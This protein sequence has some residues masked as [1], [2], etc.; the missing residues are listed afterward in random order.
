MNKLIVKG[1]IASVVAAVL[2]TLMNLFIINMPIYHVV[3][4]FIICGGLFFS[5]FL[6][7]KIFIYD[8]DKAVLMGIIQLAD[9]IALIEVTCIAMTGIENKVNAGIAFVI[10]EFLFIGLLVTTFSARTLERKNKLS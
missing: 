2:V 8:K 4:L 1:I 6:M 7:I 5:L 10:W 3:A 9:G